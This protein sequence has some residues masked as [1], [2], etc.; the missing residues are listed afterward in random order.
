M[1]RRAFIAGLGGAAAWPMVARG[2][3]GK[4]R[5]LL[6]YLAGATQAEASEFIKILLDAL[7]QQG[8][9]ENRDFDIAY[10]FADRRYDRLQPLAKELVALNPDVIITP[11]GEVAVLA[12]KEATQKI[13]IVCPTLGD[14]V[15]AGIIS[16]FNQPGGNITGVSLIV[17]HLPQ[18]QLELAVEALPGTSTFG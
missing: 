8:R 9:L 10:R 16:S 2:Q 6:G 15:R 11:S 18:K 5:A 1:K 12:I 17:E 13:P 4:K 7:Q 14:P 3:V